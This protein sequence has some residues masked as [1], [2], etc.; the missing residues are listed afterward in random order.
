MNRI[1]KNV[2]AV[3]IG[4]LGGSIV[5][6][7]LIE[8]GHK[9]FPIAGFDLNDMNSLASLMPTLDPMYFIFPFLA[10]ALGTLVGALLAGRIATTHKMKFSMAIGGLFLV[11]GIMINFM[12]PG[13]TWFAVVDVL[14]AYIPM[15]WIGGKL[16]QKYNNI[17]HL[18]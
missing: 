2:L 11:G 1:F 5:N 7:G 16:A 17:K 3:I 15:A 12:L 8:L 13:P 10:H 18:S 14:I 9:V 6:M 4:W